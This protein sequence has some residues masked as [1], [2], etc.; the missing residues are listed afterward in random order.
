[1][2]YTK[3]NWVN[4]T[5]K[6]N[7]TNLNHIEDGIEKSYGQFLLAVTDTAP[8]ECS[9]GDKYYNTTTN[10]IYTATGTDTWGSTGVDAEIGVFYIVLDTQNIY[11]YNGTT[12]VSVGGG[13]GGSQVV[14]EPDE[15]TEDTKLYIESND[16]DAQY[17]VIEDEYSTSEVKTNKVWIDGKPI[18]RKVINVSGTYYGTSDINTGLTNIDTIY[19][20]KAFA[21]NNT[22]TNILPLP[23]VYTAIEPVIGI[24]VAEDG[25]FIGIRPGSAYDGTTRYLTEI[26]VVLEYT[27]GGNS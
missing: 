16:L 13:G 1:M 6:I 23:Y 24:F 2:A 12:L 14:V 22:S 19:I 11:T 25:S 8:S 18:Y 26:T 20:E 21:K 3:T 5:T 15:P 17:E 9:T 10:K 7:A 4:N 27:K